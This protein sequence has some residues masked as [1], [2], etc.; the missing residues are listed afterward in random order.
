MVSLQEVFGQT[1]ASLGFFDVLLPFLLFFALTFGLLQQTPILKDVKEKRQI[2]AII[3]ASI[4]FFIVN[5]TPGGATL[6]ALFTALFGQGAIVLA[7]ILLAV[8]FL[9]IVPGIRGEV[10]PSS[11]WGKAVIALLVL[12][13]V[14]VFFASGVGAAIGL[15]FGLS[16]GTPGGFQIGLDM[17]LT[18]A[19]L[20]F[21]FG[22]ILWLLRSG[23]GE[24]GQTAPAGHKG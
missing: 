4:A 9:T 5:F 2:N 17:I 6:G 8:L 13:A 1:L 11:K 14:L 21:I 20:G 24:E 16:F 23:K 19:M 22:A 3:A 15:T 12:I 10:S 18:I 7:G